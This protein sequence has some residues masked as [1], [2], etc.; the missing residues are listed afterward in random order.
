MIIQRTLF[1]CSGLYIGRSLIRYLCNLPLNG[2]SELLQSIPL[3]KLQGN[4]SS[5]ELSDLKP[6]RLETTE[7][8]DGAVPY[9][10][11]E[12]RSDMPLAL[13]FEAYF[14]QFD[15]KDQT[16]YTIGIFIEQ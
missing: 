15:E 11:R 10:D 14:L 16:R 3:Q 8:Y 5:L 1:G 12:I 2:Q 9:V 4:G 6:L 7:N 13:Y